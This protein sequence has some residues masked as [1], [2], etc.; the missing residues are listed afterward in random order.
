MVT[1]DALWVPIVVSAILVFVAS[2]VAW[3]VLPHHK[4]DY[5]GLPDE[6]S[7]R[8]VLRKQNLAPGQYLIPHCADRKKMN[9]PELLHKYDEGP[10][11]VLTITRT[12][13]PRMGRNMAQWILYCLII[14]YMVAYVVGRVLGPGAPYLEVF[15]AVGTAAWLGYAGAVVTSA[16]WRFRPWS[17]A[18]KDVLDGLVYACLTAGVFGWLWPK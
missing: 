1:L 8:Q 15:R 13:R 4:S 11:G 3:M 12:G 6:E 16:I 9:E 18:W 7:V 5:K 10:I 14:S 17:T 2:S